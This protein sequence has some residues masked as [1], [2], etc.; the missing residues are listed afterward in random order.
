MHGIA[1]LAVFAFMV[2]LP[3]A[4]ALRRLRHIDAAENAPVERAEVEGPV[5]P[6]IAESLPVA[7][8]GMNGAKVESNV[9]IEGTDVVAVAD[10]GSQVRGT[11]PGPAGAEVLLK[12]QAVAAR[13]RAETLAAIAR[14]AAAK[15]AALEAKYAEELAS[16]ATQEMRRA[17]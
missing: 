3:C 4:V 10:S 13:A 8:S 1:T 6:W 11:G 17:A 5:L 16:R 12:A 15:A 2:M 7:G 9:K 14:A